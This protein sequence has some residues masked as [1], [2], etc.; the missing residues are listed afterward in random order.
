M[1]DLL[2]DTQSVPASPAAGQIVIYGDSTTK[3]L[4]TKDEGGFV[5]RLSFRNNF[6][7][8]SQTPPASTLTYIDGTNI[9]IPPG[10]LQV[11]TWFRWKFQMRKTAAGIATSTFSVVV[12][13]T[14]TISDTAQLSFSKPAGTAVADDAWVE[15]EALC[16]G[17]LSASGLFR[18]TFRLIHNLSATGH[19]TIPCVVKIS[20]SS[21]FD[22]TVANLIVGVVITSGAAD[23]ITIEQVYSEAINL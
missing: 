1:S 21:P 4:S 20:T 23:A 6:S 11:G 10:K 8:V 14:G 3:I 16:L 19:A 18:G 17:P 5:R 9:S 15:I 13:T 7:S 22:V 12:G 2:I